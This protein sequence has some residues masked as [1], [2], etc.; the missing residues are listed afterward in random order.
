MSP[1]T[2]STRPIQLTSEHVGWSACVAALL[3]PFTALVSPSLTA[4][5]LIIVIGLILA[6]LSMHDCAE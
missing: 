4:G 5:L 3:A 2:D 1:Y 6:A